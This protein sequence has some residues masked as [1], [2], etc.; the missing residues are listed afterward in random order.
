MIEI[1]EAI[2]NYQFMRNALA[3]SLLASIVCGIVGVIVTEKKLLMMSG[4]IAHTAYGGVGLGYLCGFEP[5]LGAIGFSLAAALGIG[6]V[7]RRAG[8]HSEVM[9]ALFWSLGMAL[10]VLFVSFMPVY[11]PDMSSYLFG[12][13]LTVSESN[14]AVMGVLT[15]IILAAVLIFYNDWKAFLFDPEFAGIIG[16]RSTLF[17]YL[18]LVLVALT[19]VTLIR[20]A[21]IILTIALL[22]APA[23]ISKLFSRRF[24]GRMLLASVI[25]G[26]ICLTGLC[27]SYFFDLPSGSVI[28]VLSV[29]C[30]FAAL[31]VS[32]LRDGRRSK[33]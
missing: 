26:V 13:I 21:G 20:V 7:K 24:G 33:R 15:A 25:G 27:L 9:I 28:I 29:L 14:L 1:F 10:G 18:T 6:C 2:V 31:G 23:A 32:R 12:N 11:P 17:E 5:M 8:A 19:S 22:T 4:G 30:Y 3:A 16:F